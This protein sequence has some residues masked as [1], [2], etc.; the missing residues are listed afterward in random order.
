MKKEL[1]KVISQCTKSVAIHSVNSCCMTVFG[2]EPEP[3]SL[4]K[5]QK[6]SLLSSKGAAVNGK[7]K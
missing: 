4:K 7:D 3:K 2:Q 1:I 5:Y 6:K